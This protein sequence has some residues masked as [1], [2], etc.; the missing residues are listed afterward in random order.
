MACED[1]NAALPAPAHPMANPGYG[2]RPVPD[3]LPSRPGCFDYLPPRERYV[4]AFIDRLPDGAAMDA[5]TL[6]KALPLYGQQAVRTA[7]NEL[8]RAGHLRRVRRRAEGDA[9]GEGVTRWVF[10]T[11][12]SR[13][14]RDSE[15]WARFLVGDVPSEARPE[16][17]AE[18]C[19][20]SVPPGA[21]GDVPP[22]KSQQ[23]EQADPSQPA[24]R[25]HPSLAYRV[26]AQLG[27]TEPRLP[28]SA[29]DCA[30]LEEVASAWLARGATVDLL[31]QSLVAG[32]PEHVYSPRAFVQRRLRDKMPPELPAAEEGPASRA[33]LIMECTECR[34]PGRPEALPGGLCRACRGGTGVEAPRALP[35]AAV[36]VRAAQVRGALRMSLR[37]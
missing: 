23:A 29:A 37:S 27:R 3:Q 18:A 7:L 2:K 13:T 6:A 12:W 22:Q 4:A 14:A 17:S 10:R 31:T 28:L 34:V 8:S 30:A 21:P 35:P 25:P 33:R 16:T 15:W 11:Y 36:H 20:P 26:L 32:L 1:F 24:E 5:K 9:T 19:P